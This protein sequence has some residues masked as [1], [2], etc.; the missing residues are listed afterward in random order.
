MRLISFIAKRHLICWNCPRGVETVFPIRVCLDPGSTIIWGFWLLCVTFVAV[1]T[2]HIVANHFI[3]HCSF[4]QCYG[5]FVPA[6]WCLFHWDPSVIPA[7]IMISKYNLY[8][9]QKIPQMPQVMCTDVNP[10]NQ[11]LAA[12]LLNTVAHRTRVPSL[13]KPDVHIYKFQFFQCFPHNAWLTIH[14][15]FPGWMLL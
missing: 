3:Q 11:Q 13:W 1:N 2:I 6:A 5:S 12:D 4:T 9:F 7:T 15:K 8:T 14:Q 10:E